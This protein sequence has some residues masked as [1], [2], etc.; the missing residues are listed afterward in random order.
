MTFPL[1]IIDLGIVPTNLK[2]PTQTEFLAKIHIRIMSLYFKRL[3]HDH[4]QDENLSGVL[5]QFLESQ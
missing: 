4:Y 1:S 3:L 5:M 2:K